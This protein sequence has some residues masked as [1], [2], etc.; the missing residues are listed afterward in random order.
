ML[1]VP[2]SLARGL[3]RT[4]AIAQG[5]R[6]GIPFGNAGRRH[7]SSSRGRLRKS[8]DPRL[9]DSFVLHNE[10]FADPMAHAHGMRVVVSNYGGI[11]EQ[12]KRGEASERPYDERLLLS[13]SL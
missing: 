7:L 10:A 11:G 3:L 8:A 6:G 2:S 9:A 13:F 1:R 4:R 12:G 5:E